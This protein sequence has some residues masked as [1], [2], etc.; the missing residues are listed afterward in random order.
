MQ[1]MSFQNAKFKS[2]QSDLYEYLSYTFVKATL[3]KISIL[4]GQY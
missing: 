1:K 2:E 4:L 3:Y